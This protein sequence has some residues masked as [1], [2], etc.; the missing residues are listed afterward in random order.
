M[1]E[2]PFG[3][4]RVKVVALSVID[5]ERA[6]KFYGAILGLPPAYEGGERVGYSLGETMLMLKSNWYASP[7]QD[8]NPRI[9]IETEDALR[10]ERALRERGVTISDPVNLYDEFYVGGFLDSEGNKLWFCSPAKS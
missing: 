7:T 3:F 8:P 4:Q 9:T 1:N 5:S 2:S 6:D 10:T